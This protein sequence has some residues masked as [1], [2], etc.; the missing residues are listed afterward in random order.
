MNF[1]AFLGGL[2]GSVQAKMAPRRSKM[3]PRRPKMAPRRS[4][5]GQEWLQG[6]F[7][8]RSDAPKILK[9]ANMLTFTKILKKPRKF[10][11]F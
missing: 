9:N 1:K 8:T 3:A 7:K 4:Q 5:D 11:V 2:G 6:A 10:R